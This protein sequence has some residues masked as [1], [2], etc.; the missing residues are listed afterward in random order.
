MVLLSLCMIIKNEEQFLDQCLSSVQDLVEEIIVVDTG[1]TD[2]TK[3]IAENFSHAHPNIVFK[4]VD[5]VWNDDFSAARNESLK[6]ASGDWILVLDADEVLDNYGKEN[7]RAAIKGSNR[8]NNLAYS[9]PQ[10]HYTNEFTNHVD[11]VL[12][13]R[14]YPEF[15]RFKG[16][17]A[18]FVVRL[19][20][21]VSQIKFDYCVH[22]TIQPSLDGCESKALFLDAPL[23]HYQELKKQGSVKAK[24]EFYFRLSLNN[25]KKYPDYA[26]SYNDAAIYY[27]IYLKDHK[28]ALDYAEKAY[29]LDAK[30]SG[31][32][33]QK[34]EVVLN[35]AYRLRDAGK[36]D[37]AI[38]ILEQFLEKDQD[39]R[40]YRELGYLFYHQNDL[41]KSLEYYKQ[42]L[43]FKLSDATLQR[44][45]AWLEEKLRDK[46]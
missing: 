32:K 3:E 34:I 18:T 42:A 40:V 23:H 33:S 41:L 29:T 37:Q 1:S 44:S 35:Y 28:K 19:F 6:Y 2:K 21:K 12:L 24:Q 27:A 45:I 8:S 4:M 14:S 46:K 25:I 31:Q 22:E 17:Y 39:E 20:R 10:I 36:E 7:I 9:L 38:V 5:F 13:D 11:F 16:Y 30:N 15:G 26:K 43:K